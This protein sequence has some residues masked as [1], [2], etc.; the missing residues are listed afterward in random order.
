MKYTRMKQDSS[1]TQA[2]LKKSEKE[3][4][5]LT[6]Y[7]TLCQILDENTKTSQNQKNTHH[8]LQ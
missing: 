3:I 2:R 4:Y 7:D 6:L 1:K 8:F 5:F